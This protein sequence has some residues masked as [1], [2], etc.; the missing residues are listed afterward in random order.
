MKIIYK[1]TKTF[2]HQWIKRKQYG[3][4]QKMSQSTVTTILDTSKHMNL[5]LVG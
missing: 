3:V 4:D 2:L 5:M 1:A